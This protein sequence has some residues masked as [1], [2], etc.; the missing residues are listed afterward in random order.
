[1]AILQAY[2]LPAIMLLLGAGLAFER[3][4]TDGATALGAV[5]GLVL[6]LLLNRTL[7]GWGGVPQVRLTNNAGA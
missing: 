6:A 1:M 5:A 2:L 3:F 7:P 4:G